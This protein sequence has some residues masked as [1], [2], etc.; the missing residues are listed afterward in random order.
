MK[1]KKKKQEEYYAKKIS[2]LRCHFATFK[3]MKINRRKIPKNVSLLVV[4]NVLC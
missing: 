2:S 3:N 1:I 4:V